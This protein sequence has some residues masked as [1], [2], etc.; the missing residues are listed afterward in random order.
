[1]IEKEKSS[2]RTELKQGKAV[3]VVILPHSFEECKR[4]R[5]GQRCAG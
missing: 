5:G 4:G 1:M 2:E 3:Y